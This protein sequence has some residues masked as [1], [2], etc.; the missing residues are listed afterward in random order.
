MFSATHEV[1]GKTIDNRCNRDM[2]GEAKTIH[3]KMK[4][5]VVICFYLIKLFL[6]IFYILCWASQKK[7][8]DILNTLNYISSTKRHLQ[9]FQDSGWTI[10]LK[11]Q[12]PSVKNMVLL[13]LILVFVIWKVQGVLVN[14]KD[15]V[16]VQHHYHFDIFNVAINFQLIDD[17]I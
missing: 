11:V 7:S 3:R 4:S 6:E 8:L 1:L 15:Y 17:T 5:F 13:C 14:K 12:F 2:H 9:E 10:L 16:I